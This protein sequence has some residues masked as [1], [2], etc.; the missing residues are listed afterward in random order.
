MIQ[1]DA[2][3][4]LPIPTLAELFIMSD[5]LRT[6]LIAVR[7]CEGNAGQQPRTVEHVIYRE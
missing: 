7:N 6:P 2:A 3:L 1:R 4:V 5:G